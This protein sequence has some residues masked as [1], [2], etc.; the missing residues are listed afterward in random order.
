MESTPGGGMDDGM[1]D[2]HDESTPVVE[3]ERY[4]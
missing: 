4:D 3:F 1:M 2:G